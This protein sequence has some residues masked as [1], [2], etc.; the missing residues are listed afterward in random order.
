MAYRDV[1]P[2]SPQTAGLG[3]MTPNTVVM[4]F[5]D[6]AEPRDFLEDVQGLQA[7]KKILSKLRRERSGDEKGHVYK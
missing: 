4:G 3:G 6:T 5:H 7:R 2:T 1:T